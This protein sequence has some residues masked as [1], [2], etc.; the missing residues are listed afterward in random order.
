MSWTAVDAESL[1]QLLDSGLMKKA[2][3]EVMKEI[4]GLDSLS[5]TDLADL[6]R[7]LEK[8]GKVQGML[9][10][11]EIFEELTEKEEEENATGTTSESS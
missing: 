11:R 2:W 1:K 7:A 8:R 10:V 6:N 9:R 4:A 5:G 3:N